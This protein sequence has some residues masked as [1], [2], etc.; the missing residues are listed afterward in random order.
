MTVPLIGLGHGLTL[1][2]LAEFVVEPAIPDGVQF[3]QRDRGSDLTIHEQGAFCVLQWAVID[4]LD[5]LETLLTQIGLEEDADQRAAVTAYLPTRRHYIWHVYN[6]YASF[7]A[8]L[9]YQFNPSGLA[10][11][12]DSLVITD[13]GV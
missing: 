9:T 3:A 6:A 8:T 2:Q 11:I 7:P 12:L 10:V 5:D 13:A 4:G 1:G